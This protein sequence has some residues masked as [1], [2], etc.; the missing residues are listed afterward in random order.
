MPNR[1]QYSACGVCEGMQ[2]VALSAA[3]PAAVAV[4]AQP[5]FSLLD[6]VVQQQR[7]WHQQLLSALT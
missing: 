3:L 2:L 7:Y 1:Q 5:Q 4:G 6:R